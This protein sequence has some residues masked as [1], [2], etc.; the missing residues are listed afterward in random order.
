MSHQ[1]IPASF[2]AD[3]NDR[4]DIVAMISAS[5]TLKK[6]GAHFK[7]L[8][9]FHNEKSPSFTVSAARNSYHCFG[10]GAHGNAVS[11]LMD[12]DGYTFLDA[13]RELAARAGMPMPDRLSLPQH[14]SNV[15]RASL[16]E[17]MTKAQAFY[18]DSLLRSPACQAA[19]DYARKRGLTK[20]TLKRFL[21]GASPPAWQGLSEAF[22]DYEHNSDLVNCG[23]VKI[24]AV[25]DS[26]ERRYDT[27]RNRLMFGVRD[28][29]GRIVAFG[30]RALSDNDEDQPKYLNSP[31][32][33]IFDKSNT[34]FGLY[35]SRDFIR[36]MKCV[37]VV[38]G[39]M[40]VIMLHQ[41]GVANA[42]AAL[43]TA[44]TEQHYT[45]LMGHTSEP[46]FCFDGD[47][48]GIK[49]AW[50][51]LEVISPLIKDE[52]SPRFMLLPD[53]LDPDEFV[54][55]HGAQEFFRIGSCAPGFAQ[56]LLTTLSQKHNAL[57]T[58]DDRARFTQE[59]QSVASSLSNAPVLKRLIFK[60]I[61]QLAS[62]QTVAPEL[63]TRRRPSVDPLWDR[64]VQAIERCPQT[65][66]TLRADL[67]SALRVD[68]PGHLLVIDALKALDA[69]SR[70]VDVPPLQAEVAN[71]LLDKALEL[72][73]AKQLEE[74]LDSLRS[75]F[76]CGEISDAEY[77]KAALALRS[78]QPRQPK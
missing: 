76:Q 19:R 22:P 38:E 14:E 37:Y 24:K 45:K 78:A 9:P 15:D 44:F 52:H 2:I 48:A 7:G 53:K 20:S 41:H 4:A 34:L 16:F 17:T 13:I 73:D 1:Q 62:G 77:T 61:Q 27:F 65:A 31:E 11:W 69:D 51:T 33:P 30:G 67:I 23:L 12:H 29:R 47:A 64:L 32:S 60:E 56:H 49:A 6:G 42:V 21:L 36:R 10:C 18:L 58:I 46:I 3:V 72:I 25:S 28:I 26:S 5:V 50:R 35:E 43:G 74:E 63:K 70:A 54:Q 59:A 71:R 39:Y 66:L 57:A 68:H 75:R 40:D 8:C 55:A